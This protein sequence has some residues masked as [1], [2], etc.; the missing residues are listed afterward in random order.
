MWNRADEIKI[1]LFKLDD[2]FDESIESWAQTES[3]FTN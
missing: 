1:D 3:D 2:K